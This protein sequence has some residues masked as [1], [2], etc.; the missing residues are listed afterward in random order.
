MLLRDVR[1]L[2]EKEGKKEKNNSLPC[3][4]VEN[5]DSLSDN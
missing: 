1:K 5:T 3:N 4:Q 2:E